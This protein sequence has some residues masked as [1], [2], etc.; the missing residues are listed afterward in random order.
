MKK[1]VARITL[2]ILLSVSLPVSA[3]AS[4][5]GCQ[6]ADGLN[7]CARFTVKSVKKIGSCEVKF[8]IN[9]QDLRNCKRATDLSDAAFNGIA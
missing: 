1:V 5:V 6:E 9:R 4:D 2:L 8:L 7:N 3:E